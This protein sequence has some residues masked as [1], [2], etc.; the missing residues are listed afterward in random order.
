MAIDSRDKRASVLQF[1]SAAAWAPNT[2]DAML[3]LEEDRQHMLKLYR[4][5]TTVEGGGAPVFG[6]AI[7]D[8]DTF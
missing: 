1:Q 5:I 3:A 7:C 8:C 4:G 6:S 2:P